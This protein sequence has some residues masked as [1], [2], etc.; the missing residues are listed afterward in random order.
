MKQLTIGQL[1]RCAAVNVETVRYYERRGLMPAPARRESGYRLYTDDDLERMR[2]IRR[3]KDLGFT[4]REI[5]DLLM[6]RSSPDSRCSDVRERA[7]RKIEAIEA[8]IQDLQ[9]MRCTLARLSASC[10][11][12]MS[13][14][15]CPVLGALESD[16]KDSTIDRS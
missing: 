9:Q 16:A 7:C 8:K 10:V 14:E 12:A 5:E 2:F 3:A 11:E 6:I 4:L 13:K 15:E 1:A